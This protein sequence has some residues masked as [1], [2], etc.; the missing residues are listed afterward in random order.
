MFR[1]ITMSGIIVKAGCQGLFGSECDEIID[2]RSPLEFQQDHVPGAINLPVLS[3]AERSQVGTIYKQVSA[4]EARQIGA[5][6]VS[7]NIATHIEAHFLKKEKDYRPL[8]YCWRGG[9]RSESLAT[10]LSQI[11]WQVNLLNGGY[12]TYRRMVIE[13]IESRMED[14]SFVVLNGFTGVG[15]T[16][17]LDQLAEMGEQVL[18]LEGLA[19]HKGSV[20]GGDPENPQPA[21]KQFESLLFQKLR[22]IDSNRVVFLEAES[23]KIGKLNVPNPLWQKM[24][25]SPVIELNASLEN[26]AK[27]IALSLI[28]I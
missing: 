23:A 21:Q 5:A 22:E 27:H 15:K 2:V 6:M 28:H 9:Q 25:Q 10:V 16:A 12:R 19:Q 8:V 3:D 4:F 18:D 24:K 11:G 13:T 1:I 14:L 7:R 17:V 20:F 26:R